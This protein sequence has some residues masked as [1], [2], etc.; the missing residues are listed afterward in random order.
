VNNLR[1]LQYATD[2]DPTLLA[3]LQERTDRKRMRAK[4]MT[5]ATCGESHYDNRAPTDICDDCLLELWTYRR[6][7]KA[8]E[9]KGDDGGMV[10]VQI[11]SRPHDLAYPGL[12][13]DD[14]PPAD[15]VFA[16][17]GSYG[18]VEDASRTAQ[19]LFCELFA[20]LGAMLPVPPDKV[21][22]AEPGLPG[23]NWRGGIHETHSA[24]ITEKARDVIQALWFFMCWVSAASHQTG[25]NKGSNLLMQMNLGSMTTDQ[26]NDQIAQQTQFLARRREKAATGKD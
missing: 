11:S 8:A 6:L 7:K 4:L 22:S 5:C 2:G 24:F 19:G 21:I 16:R 15:A 13:C 17:A 14:K 20:E 1:K 12:D 18:G 9:S 3:K 23:V 25:L 26:F 10:A